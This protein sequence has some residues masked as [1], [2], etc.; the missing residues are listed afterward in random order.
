METAL[1]VMF[2]LLLTQAIVNIATTHCGT[3]CPRCRPKD[4]I[5]L[6]RG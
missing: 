2:A 4:K 3:D 6:K 1:W 5:F